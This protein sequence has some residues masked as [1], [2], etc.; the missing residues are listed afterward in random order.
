M[1]RV[2]EPGGTLLIANLTSFST[3][4][5]PGRVRDADGRPLHCHPIDNYLDERAEVAQF[6]G[7]RVVNWHR[8]LS[9]YMQL[10][11]GA[12]LRLVWFDEPASVGGTPARIETSRRRPWCLVMAWQKEAGSYKAAERPVRD[13]AAS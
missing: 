2:L 4:A 13:A 1:V 8:P 10:L 9:A 3:A 7:I 5:V 12:G 6:S 11:L